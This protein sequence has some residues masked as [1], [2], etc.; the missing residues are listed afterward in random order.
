MSKLS[1]S[2][3]KRNETKKPPS[4]L[5][6]SASD[7]SSFCTSIPLPTQGA[8]PTEANQQSSG[9]RKDGCPSQSSSAQTIEKE[10]TQERV[11]RSA[12]FEETVE[13]A[14]DECV[15]T[16]V[17][18][19]CGKVGVT[20][21]HVKTCGAR[22][23]LKGAGLIEAV[24]LVERQGRERRALGLPLAPVQEKPSKPK[25]GKSKSVKR[26]LKK[27]DDGGVDPD[28]AVAMALSISEE[29]HRLRGAGEE[30]VVSKY[31]VGGDFDRKSSEKEIAVQGSHGD[32]VEARMWLPQVSS[33]PVKKKKRGKRKEKETTVLQLRT[34]EE[35][36]RLLGDRVSETLVEVPT[37]QSRRPLGT[38][39]Q[40]LKI[41]Q[42]WR[43]PAQLD[44]VSNKG[45]IARGLVKYLTPADEVHELEN[46]EMIPQNPLPS[47][48]LAS[49]SSAWLSLLKSGAGTD[50]V[51]VC[52]GEAELCCHSLVLNTRAPRILCD[53]ILETSKDGKAKQMLILSNY[54]AS[55]LQLLLKF[56]YGGVLDCDAVTSRESLP[57]IEEL[58]RKWG[59]TEVVKWLEQVEVQ[60]EETTEDPEEGREGD[61]FAIGK[62]VEEV[63]EEEQVEDQVAGTQ[64]LDAL[65]NH[66]E[67]ENQN[68]EKVGD[69]DDMSEV[70]MEEWDSVCQYMTQRVRN[71]IVEE[72]SDSSDEDTQS[73]TEESCAEVLESEQ[74]DSNVN[75]TD[76]AS[77]RVG[78]EG[79][80][81]PGNSSDKENNSPPGSK[82]SSATILKPIPCFAVLERSTTLNSPVQSTSAY[83]NNDHSL[84]VVGRRSISTP[85]VLRDSS[86]TYS[87]PV[88]PPSP[89]M[90]DSEE[91]G[92]SQVSNEVEEI[93]KERGG[94]SELAVDAECFKPLSQKDFNKRSSLKR[95]S[96][97]DEE[98]EPKRLKSE[99]VTAL[100]K[101]SFQINEDLSYCE[102][103]PTPTKYSP[104]EK[105]NSPPSSPCVPSPTSTS[106]GQAQDPLVDLTQ[107]STSSTHN[108]EDDSLE[109]PTPTRYSPL[110]LSSNSSR[111]SSTSS[112]GTYNKAPPHPAAASSNEGSTLASE[113]E[114][115][116]ELLSELSYLTTRL[117][118]VGAPEDE[119]SS[120]LICLLQ[121]EVSI[122]SYFPK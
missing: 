65:L 11:P 112:S 27:D 59:L 3:A 99:I 82:K 32:K 104:F 33:S 28:L 56:I 40:F 45:L 88:C 23:G 39:R 2:K 43:L 89:D 47:C 70:E 74:V 58:A 64:C 106:P 31:F 61:G 97:N 80:P 53:A 71:S 77:E 42:F 92:E 67:E 85:Q 83:L 96:I 29:Q 10:D 21:S 16:T 86:K 94:F 113:D 84:S 30:V 107:S 75:S 76:T 25:S 101:R 62:V 19:V 90:F 17:C 5:N 100:N 51:M 117:S 6:D 9:G 41:P 66:L 49:L 7:F 34:D 87:Q 37:V 36:S 48:P 103:L 68:S 98:T 108:D 121:L 69:N 55:V 95:K 109:I 18:P 8:P 54:E 24:K 15:Q 72:K 115:E 111:V 12:I 22:H 119:I 122:S 13:E 110:P 52:K 91:E 93:E 35:R 14:V 46:K 79:E 38:C 118:A 78:C 105:H 44:I 50:T 81:Q 73:L 116:D 57:Q 4:A 102:D 114:E 120:C 26:P 20:G 1:R 60:E 63:E